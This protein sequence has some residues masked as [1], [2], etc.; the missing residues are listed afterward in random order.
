LSNPQNED[1]KNDNNYFLL[2]S[3]LE[4]VSYKKID[5]AI[6]ACNELRL[7]LKIVGVGKGEKSLRHLAGPTIEFLGQLTDEKLSYYYKNCRALIFTG[8]EDF[9]LVMVEAQSFGKPVIAFRNGGAIDIIKDGVTGEF[10]NEQSKESLA[11]TL[12]NFKD[13]R[14][15]SKLCMENAKR[16]SFASF[17]KDF[18]EFL[19]KQLA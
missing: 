19:S 12:V 1:L 15:N 3:R 16:F 2:V 11:K 10:F 14:Y 5:I 4:R 13:N 7:P 9:G 18:Q 6:K 17:E 8:I